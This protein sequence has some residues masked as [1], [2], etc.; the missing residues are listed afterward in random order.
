MGN[1]IDRSELLANQV[2]EV[3]GM[4]REMK[5]RERNSRAEAIKW[6]IDEMNHIGK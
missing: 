4:V 2:G 6:V 3:K 1:A 5:I